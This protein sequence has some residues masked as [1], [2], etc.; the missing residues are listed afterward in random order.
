[1]HEL[2]GSKLDSPDYACAL[3]CLAP[4]MQNGF[5]HLDLESIELAAR[6]K[7]ATLSLDWLK[8]FQEHASRVSVGIKL[9]LLGHE[10]MGRVFED[11][12]GQLHRLLTTNEK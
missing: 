10:E 7:R 6:G 2:E 9:S 11:K 3:I 4:S 8:E 5:H 1:M 12:I